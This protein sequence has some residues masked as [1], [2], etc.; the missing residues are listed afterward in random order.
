MKFKIGNKVKLNLSE[1]YENG[2]I[3]SELDKFLENISVSKNGPFTIKDIEQTL[4]APYILAEFPESS[5]YDNELEIALDEITPYIDHTCLSVTAT[6]KDIRLTARKAAENNTAS[7]C[8][9]SSNLDIVIDELSKINSS[10]SV[11]CVVGFPHG[12]TSTDTKI[13]EAQNAVMHGAN[14]I[15]FVVNIGWIKSGRWDD[16]SRE[17][18]KIKNTL[19]NNIL[20]KVIVETS[21]LTMEEKVTICNICIDNNVDFIKTSTGFSTGGATVEDIRL[22]NNIIKRRKSPMKIKASGGISD[23]NFAMELINAGASR[24]GSSRLI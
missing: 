15:D 8:V 11:C 9:A 6:D 5:F 16:V 21:L 4:P 23:V 10:T 18:Y 3:S 12:N 2:E 19:N 13:F 22:F 1:I 7:V 24:I 20:L 17:I 14:E